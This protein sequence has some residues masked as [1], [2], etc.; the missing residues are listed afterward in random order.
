MPLTVLRRSNL[1]ACKESDG[2]C[3]NIIK[4]TNDIDFKK[5]T[6]RSKVKG[7]ILT[8]HSEDEEDVV[9]FQREDQ[10]KGSDMQFAH[11]LR[12]EKDEMVQVNATRFATEKRIFFAVCKAGFGEIRETSLA[13]VCSVV[14]EY[15][16][17]K[18]LEGKETCSSS[19]GDEEQQESVVDP[20]VYLR[21]RRIKDNRYH[22]M[23][24]SLQ[25]QL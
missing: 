4:L 10:C 16:K 3:F 14:H 5:V 9:L 11:I 2:Y 15:E 1:I 6:N 21:Q 13:F 22:L 8:F 25:F 12:K 17:S 18:T 23:L 24:A 7:N 19:S 20:V